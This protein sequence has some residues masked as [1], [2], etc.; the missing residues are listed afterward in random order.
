MP[1]PTLLEAIEAKCN[2]TYRIKRLG[3]DIVVRGQAFTYLQKDL[4]LDGWRGVTYANLVRLAE[5]NSR[6]GFDR[7]RGRRIFHGGIMGFGGECDV[8]Y[9]VESARTATDEQLTAEEDAAFKKM[10]DDCNS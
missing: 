4:R 10:M 1:R 7:G 3:P 5:G 6:F 8:F 9:L 2:G